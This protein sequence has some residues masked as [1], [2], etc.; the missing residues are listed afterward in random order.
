MDIRTKMLANSISKLYRRGA[1]KNIRGILEKTHNVDVAT[2]LEV[3]NTEE[4][5]SIFQWVGDSQR[6]AHILSHLEKNSQ[7]EIIY[8]LQIEELQ[9]IF[10][11]MESDDAADLLASL[12]ETMSQQIL[13][14]LEKNEQEEVEELMTYPSDSAGGLMSSEYL[15]LK[16]GF[17]VNQAI[18]KIQSMDEDLMSFYIYV[19]NDS[20]HLVGVLSLKQLLLS[21]PKEKLSKIMSTEVISV[22]LGSHQREV[23]RVV[24]KYD[25]LSVPVVDES[26]KLV[27][28]ITVDDIIDVI[29]K[30]A[31]EDIQAMGMGVASLE[32]S[33]WVHF[34]SRL[35][36]LIL[37][38]LGGGTGSFLLWNFLK[39]FKINESLMSNMVFL[40]L[41]LLIVSTMS[42]QTVTLLVGFL[43][44]HG[45]TT[46]KFWLDLKKE[47]TVSL[48]LSFSFTC[49]LAVSIYSFQ[50]NISQSLSLG[51]LLGFQ[52]LGAFVISV[53]VP[54]FIGRLRFDPIVVAPS[55]SVILSNVYAVA[56]LVF[57]Y[58]SR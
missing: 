6:Q 37:A 15:T 16:E 20:S 51:A 29:R 18:E 13:S 25:F 43:R 2:V 57:S 53:S 58:A 55:V 19:V 41:C 45:V 32:S 22:K 31:E 4:K 7:S 42:N 48:G 17:T 23:A 40:P 39:S 24:E 33:S 1:E 26:S 30:G 27:G 5:I 46:R 35:P 12:P 14:G 9:K 8:V 10:S 21:R 56:S 47:F 54:L 28:V 49:L 11:K 38:A 50:G 3:L 52:M 34:K 44:F 36:W